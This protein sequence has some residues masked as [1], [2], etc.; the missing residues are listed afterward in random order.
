[1][2]TETQILA[3][4]ILSVAEGTNHNEW[5][6]GV[7]P[8]TNKLVESF[9]EENKVYEMVEDKNGEFVK[10]FTGYKNEELDKILKHIKTSCEKDLSEINRFEAQTNKFGKDKIEIIKKIT[11]PYALKSENEE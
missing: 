7:Y 1:M 3:T 9:I 11:R 6:S 4:T 10:K 8:Q 2:N 5:V